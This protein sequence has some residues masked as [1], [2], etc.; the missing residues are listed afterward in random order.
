MWHG[1]H[2]RRQKRRDRHCWCSKSASKGVKKCGKIQYWNCLNVFLVGKKKQNTFSSI[3]FTTTK[4]RYK[5][6]RISWQQYAEMQKYIFRHQTVTR[7]ATVLLRWPWVRHRTEC[8]LAKTVKTW[9]EKPGSG[10]D[11]SCIPLPR[12]AD[13]MPLFKL[14][15]KKKKK[16]QS[17]VVKSAGLSMSIS[18]MPFFRKWSKKRARNL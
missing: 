4:A 17:S 12:L 14:E 18:L 3:C 5:V 10:C 9:G 8:T 7:W 6:V 15:F 13:L 16:L 1:W 11:V 2:S